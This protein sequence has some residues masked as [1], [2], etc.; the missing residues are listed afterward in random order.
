MLDHG[1][2]SPNPKFRMKKSKPK[3]IVQ[4]QRYN[5]LIN[6]SSLNKTVGKKEFEQFLESQRNLIRTKTVGVRIE[7]KQV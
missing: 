5:S 2:V 1:L 6:K 4:D 7:D 3:M